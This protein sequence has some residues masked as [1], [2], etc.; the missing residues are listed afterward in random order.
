ME[1]R[2]LSSV[3]FTAASGITFSDD[4]SSGRLRKFGIYLRDQFGSF[5][6]TPCQC[7]YVDL[8]QQVGSRS[9]YLSII[10]IV[11]RLTTLVSSFQQKRTSLCGVVSICNASATLSIDCDSPIF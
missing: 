5:D 9:I 11:I 10:D 7:H 6:F 8:P 1:F 2:S 4:N 3:S